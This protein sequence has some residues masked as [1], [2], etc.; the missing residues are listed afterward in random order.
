MAK[1]DIRKYSM[2]GIKVMH[3]HGDYVPTRPDAPIFEIDEEFW[4]DARMVNPPPHFW[5]T[6]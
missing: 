3:K 5:E 6:T 4:K 1:K 2:D